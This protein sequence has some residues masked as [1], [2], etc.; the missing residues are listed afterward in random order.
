M[1]LSNLLLL[2]ILF[3]INIVLHKS[4][5]CIDLFS[6]D[7]ANIYSKQTDSLALELID[8]NSKIKSLKSAIDKSKT[9]KN[10]IVLLFEESEG[11]R[12]LRLFEEKRSLHLENILQTLIQSQNK[13]RIKL[14]KLLTKRNL[15]LS[16]EEFDT[17]LMKEYGSETVVSFYYDELTLHEIHNPATLPGSWANNGLPIVYEYFETFALLKDISRFSKDPGS[18]SSE[19]AHIRITELSEFDLQKIEGNK[20]LRAYFEASGK[21]AWI[22]P[23]IKETYIYELEEF[24]PEYPDAHLWKIEEAIFPGFIGLD[25]RSKAKGEPGEEFKPDDE[26]STEIKIL[27]DLKVKFKA[28]DDPNRLLFMIGYTIAELSM[29]LDK[30]EGRYRLF[31]YKFRGLNTRRITDTQIPINEGCIILDIK[32]GHATILYLEALK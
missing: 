4:F 14:E 21:Y 7:Q 29:D 9:S 17:W 10:N 26:K 22:D 32:T 3:Y 15:E 31:S 18:L 11:L 23:E 16:E 1:K 30:D 28:E 2:L 25:F 6:I 27:E 19:I 8:L 20:I 5:A 24:D 12:N 13:I